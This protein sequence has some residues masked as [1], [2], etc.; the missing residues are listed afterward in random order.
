MD[1]EKRI[2]DLNEH[3]PPFMQLLGGKVV[4][5]DADEQSC[6]FEF[7]PSLDLC[8]SVDVVQGGFVTAMLDAAMSHAVFALVED[9]VGLSSYEV[10]TRYEAVTRGGAGPVYA[11]GRIRKATAK[12]PFWRQNCRILAEMTASAQSIGKIISRRPLR[13]KVGKYRW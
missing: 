1:A 2:A 13:Y 12:R 3:T 10:T 11:K 9:V 6:T 5:I 4:A 8:H 7:N